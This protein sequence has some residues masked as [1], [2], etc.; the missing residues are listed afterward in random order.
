MT[1]NG[2]HYRRNH[3]FLNKS[4]DSPFILPDDFEQNVTHVKEP[5]NEQLESALD[6]TEENQKSVVPAYMDH[7]LTMQD[8][9]PRRMST[10]ER[11]QPSWMKDYV[12]K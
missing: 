5:D 3:K 10:R 4:R 9:P 2:K 1:E 11:R 8:V 7:S 6:Q 12:S